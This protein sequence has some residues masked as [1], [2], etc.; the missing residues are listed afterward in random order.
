MFAIGHSAGGQLALW[1]GARPGLPAGA[2]GAAPRVT[3]AGAVG[4]AAVCDLRMAH[5][6]RS[7]NG[8]VRRLMGGSPRR[9]PERYELA[10]PIAR[11]PLG[12]PQLLVHGE[13]DRVVSREQSI[14]YAAAA[15]AAGDA[16]LTVVIRPGEG[17]FEHLDP[18][19]GAW[20]VVVGW[21]DERAG[22]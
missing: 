2:P 19:G 9:V 20:D 12:I 10:S 21:L 16:D 18:T 11:L 4:Q 17:H 6:R 22:E 5:A 15:R 8:V 3:L 14:G 1:A 13:R 7:G